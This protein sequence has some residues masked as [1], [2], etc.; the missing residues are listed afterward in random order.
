MLGLKNQ[1]SN[2]PEGNKP[3]SKFVEIIYLNTWNIFEILSQHN[4]SVGGSLVSSIP[5][6][7]NDFRIMQPQT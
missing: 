5:K 6:F 7:E 3:G 2:L 4:S 1:C